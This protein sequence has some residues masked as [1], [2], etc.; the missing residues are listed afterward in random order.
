MMK[1]GQRQ[2]NDVGEERTFGVDG[3]QVGILEQGHEVSLGGFLERHD[4]G[5]LEAEVGLTNEASE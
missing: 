5:R 4:S 2:T 3:S 1:K